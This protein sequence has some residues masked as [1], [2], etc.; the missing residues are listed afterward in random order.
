MRGALS[1]LV[2][3]SGVG[4]ETFAS[5]RLHFLCLWSECF[6]FLSLVLKPG[7]LCTLSLKYPSPDFITITLSSETRGSCVSYNVSG[8]SMLTK[9]FQYYF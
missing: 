8:S 7:P 9:I 6:S 2:P 4:S 1:T 3:G 5:L